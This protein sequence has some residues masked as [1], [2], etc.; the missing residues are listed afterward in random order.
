M[1][2][3]NDVREERYA[4]LRIRKRRCERTFTAC[5]A[6]SALAG[7]IELLFVGSVRC[8]ALLGK[9]VPLGLTAF[10]AN[11][12]ILVILLL[13]ICKRNRYLLGA[14]LIIWIFSCLLSMT[15]HAPVTVACII[16]SLMTSLEW[17]TLRHK[18][19]FPLFEIPIQEQEQQECS[20]DLTA[21]NLPQAPETDAMQ[22]DSRH[23]FT[24]GEM[25]SI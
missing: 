6:V 19:G 22:T 11:F 4:H 18:E 15:L 21:R 9:N 8:T 3:E 25:D 5:L 7:M 13:G 1:Y 20:I 10:A 16:I 23:N 2:T 12:G 24:P 17:N 14:A